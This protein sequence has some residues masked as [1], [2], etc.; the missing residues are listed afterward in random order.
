MTIVCSV[1]IEF[2]YEAR[3]PVL[4]IEENNDW[5]RDDFDTQS[6]LP[7]SFRKSSLSERYFA[8]TH[9]WDIHRPAKVFISCPPIGDFP[10]APMEVRHAFALPPN[11]P[12]L[13]FL[14]RAGVRFPL[15]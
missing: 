6:A 14:R 5:G 11:F 3:I 10:R 9:P 4:D 13:F 7:C 1:Q 8:S 15:P 12:L 2:S